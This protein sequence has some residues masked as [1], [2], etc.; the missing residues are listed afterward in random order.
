M[1]WM[2]SATV[3]FCSLAGF[4]GQPQ[5][6]YRVFKWQWEPNEKSFKILVPDKWMTE[7][8][9]FR[10][11]PTTGGGAAN[12]LEAKLDFSIKNDKEGTALMRWYPDMY[13]FDSRRS[14]AGQMGLF[15]AGSN[16]QGM[17][18]L[19][20]MSPE[21]F[22]IQVVLP[23]AH[24]GVSNIL[25]VSRKNL[26]DLAQAIKNEDKLIADIGFIYSASLV[27]VTYSEGSRIYEEKLIS[28]VMDL[29]QAGAGMWKNRYTFSYRAPKGR[30]KEFE[31][32]FAAIGGSLTLNPNWLVG[33][34]K[35]Q[36]VRTGIYD[37]TITEIKRISDE[38]NQQRQKNN[39]VIG[40]EM[41]L[42]LTGQEEYI[43]PFTN[44]TETG[45]NQWGHRWTSNGDFVIYCDDP[46]FD[47]N[48]I[49]EINHFEYKRSPV[50]KR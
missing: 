23:Y 3:L 32:V 9:V 50:K 16:Y 11:N 6:N 38:I 37:K 47:P 31:P 15:P 33:E 20:V 1:K 44:E 2:F 14:P 46:N 49:P 30:L 18:V 4:P 43:N 26:P 21:Q 13:Y 27:T 29:G 24:P 28:A 25:V 35:G 42:N 22:I 17:T 48:K 19:P 39:S 40:H 5:N 36:L 12:A 10:I 41:Y 8:G 7:G 34:I 45:T